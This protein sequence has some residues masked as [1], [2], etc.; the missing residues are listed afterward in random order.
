MKN[1]Q[2][3]AGLLIL[4]LGFVIGASIHPQRQKAIA[5]ATPDREYAMNIIYSVWPGWSVAK[6][7]L[8]KISSVSPSIKTSFGGVP[9]NDSAKQIEELD[10]LIER[11]VNGI[12]LNV[13]DSKTLIDTVNKA[14]SNRIP[15]VTFFCDTD[16]SKRLTFVSA[17]ERG[18]AKR[19]VE[20][21]IQKLHKPEGRNAN[22]LISTVNPGIMVMNDRIQGVKDALKE[23]PWITLIDIVRDEADDAKGSEAIASALTRGQPIDMIVGTGGR[24]AMCAISA[25]RERGLKKDDILIT[26][27]DSDKDTLQAIKDGWVEA[28]SAPNMEFMTQ[29]CV[30]ILEAYN[31]HYTSIF[32]DR[33]DIPQ[34]FIDKSNVDKFINAQK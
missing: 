3:A 20:K 19:L 23:V 29:T 31:L 11:K 24:S 33:I 26:G 27:W 28:S 34:T 4:V 14:A 7:T 8:E 22:I 9:D 25:L 30:S 1:N 12:I 18:S 15:V 6:H 16:S 5:K 21:T 32:P 13:A 17:D 10:P 2:I